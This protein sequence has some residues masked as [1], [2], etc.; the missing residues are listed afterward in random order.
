M[1]A[2]SSNNLQ[3]IIIG[4]TRRGDGCLNSKMSFTADFEN[5]D[6]DLLGNIPL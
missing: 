1:Y 2:K 4:D 5:S 3:D 6:L